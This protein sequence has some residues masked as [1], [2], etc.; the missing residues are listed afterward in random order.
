[1][2]TLMRRA[3]QMT[4]G[5]KP[6]SFKLSNEGTPLDRGLIEM[7]LKMAHVGLERAGR[8]MGGSITMKFEPE[9]ISFEYVPE[10]A[11]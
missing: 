9:E 1:M 10:P 3:I 4:N 6:L 5:D 8:D 2:D 7:A 11:P